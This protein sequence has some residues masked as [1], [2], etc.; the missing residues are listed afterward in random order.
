MSS[1]Y[2]IFE[3]SAVKCVKQDQNAP[4]GTLSGLCTSY[5]HSSKRL[6]TVKAENCSLWLYQVRFWANIKWNTVSNRGDKV[7]FLK[8]VHV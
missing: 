8:I 1:V 3:A 6:F 4:N 5:L 2:L 7:A